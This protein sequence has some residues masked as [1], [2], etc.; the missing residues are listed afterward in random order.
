MKKAVILARVSTKEQEEQGLSLPAQVTSLHD[1]AVRKSLD[2]VKE[3]VF[4]ESA[5]EKIRKKFKEMMIYIKKKKYPIVIICQNV[6]RLTRN[7]RD[8]VE[9]DDLRNKGNLEVHFVADGF[10]L[11]KDSPATEIF[12][13]DM[14]VMMSK[15]YL[16][17]L[18][19]NGNRSSRIKLEKGEWIARAP[20]GYQNIQ[21][22][23]GRRTIVLDK[24]R[25]LFIKKLFVEYASGLYSLEEMTRKLNDWGM[26]NKTAKGGP[27]TKK[28]IHQVLT[29]PFYYGVMK[30]KEQL[31]PHKY[32]KIIEK[33]L[34]DKCTLVREN[35]NRNRTKYSS[36]PFLFRGLIK[37]GYCGCSISSDIKKNKYI[38][39]RCTKHKGECDAIHVREEVITDQVK[40]VFRM[41]QIPDDI[42]EKVVELL[43][44]N[45]S[46]KKEFHERSIQHLQTEYKKTQARLDKLLDL[47]LDGSIT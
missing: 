31:Y 26:T 42:L 32:Q 44:E 25:A 34:F 3:F 43:R 36:K 47:L 20:L 1:Y 21:D 6:D 38:Y 12:L 45:T 29:T 17:I 7:F 4:Y 23:N 41:I 28:Q 8:A 35:K 46:N 19:E 39:L 11:S 30:V 27:L 24:N 18:K 22:D 2:V 5:G 10:V 14:K 40:G 16:N 9:I 15:Q 33:S 37:C 13:W